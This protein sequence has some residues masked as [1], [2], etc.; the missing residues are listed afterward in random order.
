[1]GCCM[2]KSKISAEE[3][4]RRD[5]MP[6]INVTVRQANGDFTE[7]TV[8]PW[9][10]VHQ[11]VFEGLEPGLTGLWALHEVR[12]GGEPIDSSATWESEGV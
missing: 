3:Q 12:Y 8:K 9:Q 10:N 4:R 1:M 11:S 5:A 2:S 7:I 6:P